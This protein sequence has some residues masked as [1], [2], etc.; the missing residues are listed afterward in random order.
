MAFNNSH[1]HA[2]LIGSA[3]TG[4][5]T[6]S[7]QK[8]CN[9][10]ASAD[11]VITDYSFGIFKGLTDTAGNVVTVNEYPN[12]SFGLKTAD[13]TKAGNDGQGCIE[14]PFISANVSAGVGVV[15]FNG[16]L[17]SNS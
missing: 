7:I 11:M 3:G 2:T 14:G 6:G 4:R 10:H 12:R 8:I 17:A 13:L 15:Y 9:F 16:E 1:E 5:V